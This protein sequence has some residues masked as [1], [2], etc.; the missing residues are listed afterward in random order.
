MCLPDPG[1]WCGRRPTIGR[2][3]WRI[4]PCRATGQNFRR[5]RKGKLSGLPSK[6][7]LRL[8]H[9]VLRRRRKVI[10]LVGVL[11]VGVGERLQYGVF[12]GVVRRLILW[13]P[14]FFGRVQL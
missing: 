14:F 4:Y 13:V 11:F 5:V 6:L 8:E 3:G 12:L 10:R 9:L 7:S 1:A 2:R